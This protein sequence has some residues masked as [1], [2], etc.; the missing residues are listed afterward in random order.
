MEV[1][2]GSLATMKCRV[3]HVSEEPEICHRELILQSE[4][5]QSIIVEIELIQQTRPN[6]IN[7]FR[8]KSYIASKQGR[9]KFG[10]VTKAVLK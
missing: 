2:F 7:H 10:E 8:N 3:A 1:E 9:N 4:G 5:G 6:E